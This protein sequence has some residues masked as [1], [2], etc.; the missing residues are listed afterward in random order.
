MKMV[1]EPTVIPA[2]SS[3][4][5][6]VLTT[7]DFNDYGHCCRGS[8]ISPVPSPLRLTY[9]LI[10]HGVGLGLRYSV[11]GGQG[12]FRPPSVC[13]DWA[14]ATGS[15][16]LPVAE[17]TYFEVTLTQFKHNTYKVRIGIAELTVSDH[18]VSSTR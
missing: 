8:I 9:S 1:T 12:D 7:Q 11:A 2:H 5:K 13:R 17:S 15:S 14:I 18:H 3:S 16:A 4:C 10:G 6:N